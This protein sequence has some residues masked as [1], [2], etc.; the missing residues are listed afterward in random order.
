LWSN[1]WNEN[2]QGKPKYSEKTCPSATLPTKS[3][4]GLTRARTRAA[5]WEA[6]DNRLS[7]GTAILGL[8]ADAVY[9]FLTQMS[10][11]L[12]SHGS[13]VVFW[14]TMPCSSAV[15][16][17]FGGTHCQYL[18]G[19]K[20]KPN[21]YSASGKV[22]PTKLSTCGGTACFLLVHWL[23]LRLLKFSS[24]QCPA[25]LW[26]PPSLLPSTAAAFPD[27]KAARLWSYTSTHTCLHDVVLN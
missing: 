6:G 7:Y 24:P 2:W 15:R 4:H 8:T 26:G 13:S 23:S 5:K 10:S 9:S 14:D 22:G 19:L 20:S 1:R 18:Q 21:W 25:R 12:K 11:L 3:P 27:G 17:H 16:W